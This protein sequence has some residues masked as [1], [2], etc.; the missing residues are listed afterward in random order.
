MP[1]VL[2]DAAVQLLAVYVVEL[3]HHPV[4]VHQVVEHLV[5]LTCL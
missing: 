5:S 3:R 4:V 2:L 1:F